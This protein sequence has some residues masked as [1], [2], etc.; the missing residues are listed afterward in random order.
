MSSPT[1]AQT[2]EMFDK[3][4]AKVPAEQVDRLKEFRRAHLPRR[5][6]FGDAQWEYRSLIHI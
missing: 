5:L 3:I 1:A 6:I 4:Y 2:D